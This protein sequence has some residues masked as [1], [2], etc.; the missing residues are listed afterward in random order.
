MTGFL[1]RALDFAA[2]NEKTAELT[3]KRWAQRAATARLK[4]I[5]AE[6]GAA[7]CG[8]HEIL[9]HVSPSEITPES[10]E[11]VKGAVIA[12]LLVDI[13]IPTDLLSPSDIAAAIR[14]EEVLAALYEL[15]ASLGG[16]TASLF[17]SLAAEEKR[18]RQLLL[19][20][21]HAAEDTS[22]SQGCT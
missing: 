21:F 19:T 4:S 17:S 16:E 22:F 1:Q 9:L 6:L 7:E 2:A 8:H 14:R 10:A 3:Y 12:R 20:E 18:H 5:L 13:P 15:L 11:P